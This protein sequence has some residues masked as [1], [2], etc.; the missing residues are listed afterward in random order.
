[1]KIKHFCLALGLATI[2]IIAT[3]TPKASAL[4]WTTGMNDAMSN[5]TTYPGQSFTPN[6]QGNAGSGTSPS[7]GSALLNSFSLGSNST[8]L[9]YIFSSAYTGTP[10]N[11]ASYSGSNKLGVSSAAVSGTYS[12]NSGLLLPDV[13]SQYYAYA[14]SQYMVKF[15]NNSSVVGNLFFSNGSTSTYTQG[16]GYFNFS[17]NFSSASVPWNFSPS[18]GIVLGVPL[19]I[20]LRMLKRKRALRKVLPIQDMS[21]E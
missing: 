3:N 21:V 17:A 11:L 5:F 13:T 15:T 10:A 18:E 1:M 20:G 9:L 14:D 6:Q 7:N 4:T 12:F 2:G 19:F 8:G 16:S